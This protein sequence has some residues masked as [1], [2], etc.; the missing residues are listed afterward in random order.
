MANLTPEQ[1]ERGLRDLDVDVR[2]IFENRQAEWRAK[3]EA[4][5][6]KKRHATVTAAK[7]KVEA[8]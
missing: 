1:I 5:E 2:R 3:W 8:L 4:Q 6:L 7:P